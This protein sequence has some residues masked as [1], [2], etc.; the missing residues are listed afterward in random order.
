MR[1]SI[2]LRLKGS[3]PRPV[4]MAVRSADNYRK[5]LLIWRAIGREIR[6]VGSSDRRAL[7]QSAL[8]S[9]FL[10]LRN[11]YG[12]QD[13]VLLNDALVE[14]HEV[15][16]FRVR[17]HSD[18]LYHVLPSREPAVLAAIREH[19]K[20]GDTFIDAGANIGFFSVLAGRQVGD[21]GRVLAIEMMPVTAAM[22]RQNLSLNKI[23]SAT[24]VEKALSD[25]SGG[26]LTAHFVE[27]HF[28]M[29]S[30]VRPDGS[31]MQTVEVQTTTLDEEAANVERIALIKMDLEG[32]ELNALEGAREVLAR[33][34]MIL[35]EQLGEETRPAEFLRDCGFEVRNLEGSNFIASKEG[36]GMQ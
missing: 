25:Q 9:P 24:V 3:L 2:E 34:R 10:A 5:R 8:A 19:L 1:R 20:P 17:A 26:T 12:W 18:D 33:T 30:I 23:Q 15:G 14:V 11:L 4:A 29:A 6:G 32:A 31:A 36:G 22:L 28:G 7:R 16:R 35:F 13:P 27:G 21:Q